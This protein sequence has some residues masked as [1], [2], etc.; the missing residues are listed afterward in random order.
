MAGMLLEYGAD[1]KATNE[2][3]STPFHYIVRHKVPLS[4]SKRYLFFSLL[5]KVF[6]FC[7]F[8]FLFF[9][10]CFLI[11]LFIYLFIFLFCF[12][13]F[14]YLFF[15]LCLFRTTF[16]LLLLSP[17][18]LSS[19]LPPLLPLLSSL[20]SLSSSLLFSP[21]LS[22]PFFSVNK[23]LNKREKQLARESGINLRNRSGET[24]LFYCVYYG[25]DL[26]ILQVFFFSFFFFFFFSFFFLFFFLFLILF[27]FLLS[28][29]LPLFLSSS[30][31]F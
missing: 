3:Q 31:F 5:H 28:F 17:L 9:C 19:S 22:L 23:K 16:S 11:Y 2:S 30:L 24:P 7:F 14:F 12:I 8:V 4:P 29:S 27:S 15:Y 6:F 21:L 13:Y 20:S 26:D 25:C 10:F 18:F 1:A